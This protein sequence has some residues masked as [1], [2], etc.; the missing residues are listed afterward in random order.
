MALP[1]VT[2]H[3]VDNNGAV[4]ATTYRLPDG[5]TFGQAVSVATAIAQAAQDVSSASLTHYDIT[6]QY[7]IASPVP[8]QETSDV[9]RA[10]V[11]FYRNGSA[12]ASVRV[13]SPAELLA[14][15]GGEYAGVRITPER[16]AVLGLLTKVQGLVTGALDPLGRPYGGDFTVGGITRV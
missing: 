8:A 4:A 11:L 16:L 15:V 13:P 14:E 7:D 5:T 1:R 10:A 2:L 6:W 12:I 3:W 9:R